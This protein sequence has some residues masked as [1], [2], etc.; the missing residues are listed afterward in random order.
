MERKKGL[1]IVKNITREG[2]GLIEKALKANHIAYDIIDLGMKERIPSIKGYSAVIV[3]GGPDSAN[4]GSEKIRAELALAKHCLDSGVP[5]LGICLGMQILVKAA[6][7]RV[8]KSD[9]KEVGFRDEEGEPYEVS[10]TEK[11]MNDPL[12]AGL[13]VRIGVFQLHGETV[14]LTSGMHLLGAGKHCRNQAIKIGENAYGLQFHFELTRNMLELWLRED[15][16]L[17]RVQR[18]R[19]FGDFLQVRTHYERVG[20]RIAGNFIDIALAKTK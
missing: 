11:G 5:Y 16:D 3:L 2:P 8:L 9:V 19:V 10:L 17:S 15:A 1:L 6:G 14:E 20:R 7:G 13:S 18:R 12:F 4:D